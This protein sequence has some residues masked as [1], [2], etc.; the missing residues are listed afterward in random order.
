[1]TLLTQIIMKA[2]QTKIKLCD[3]KTYE[4]VKK[5]E[6]SSVSIFPTGI[7]TE[8]EKKQA[9]TQYS[10]KLLQEYYDINKDGTTTVEEFAQKEQISSEKA[11]KLT[12]NNL[13]EQTI[14]NLEKDK[15]MLKFYDENGDGKISTD[16]YNKGLATLGLSN[17]VKSNELSEQEK[18][19]AK[20][21]ANLFATNLDMNGDG[22]ISTQEFAFFNE[23]A[24]ECDGKADGIITN[25]GESAMFQAVTGMNA[26]DKEI[27]RV[28]NK[29][30]MGEILSAEE[31]KILERGTATIRNSMKKA[32][33]LE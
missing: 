24:D 22:K 6:N 26:N 33:G 25:I 12:C 15:D 17:L 11:M 28:V 32:A 30:L 10:E 20:N 21:G 4:D 5:L 19:I 14:K 9:Y 29:Y 27:N 18:R 7:K 16:E 1:M 2:V 3:L 23:Q 13:S 31:Q 8:E